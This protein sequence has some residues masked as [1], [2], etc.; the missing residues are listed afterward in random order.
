MTWMK[1]GFFGSNILSA[2]NA[3]SPSPDNTDPHI[4]YMG[5]FS[6]TI[7][8]VSTSCF[9]HNSCG[10]DISISFKLPCLF[11]SPLDGYLI[12]VAVISNTRTWNFEF[13]LY[14]K[15]KKYP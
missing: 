12:S 8:S 11:L 4:E 3:L 13:P 9:T 5:K 10:V 2:C 15:T 7:N 1:E 6:I 14:L